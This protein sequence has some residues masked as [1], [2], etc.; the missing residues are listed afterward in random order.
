MRSLSDK[1]QGS[2]GD[3]AK[4][5]CDNGI[6]DDRIR[7]LPVNGWQGILKT[8]GDRFVDHSYF[9]T[10]GLHWANTNGGFRDDVP[11]VFAFREGLQDTASYEWSER[12]SEIVGE[13]MVYL[14]IEEPGG[15]FTVCECISSAVYLVINEAV[16]PS[17]YYITDKK[18]NWLIS[19][20]HH[21][22]VMF[23][24]ESLDV[25]KIKAVVIKKEEGKK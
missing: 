3:I 12:L 19:E 1:W 5:I 17:D 10:Y 20:N 16:Y 18:F 9:Y 13:Q 7:L 6:E 2:R 15:K 24:G 11:V 21:D 4:Y 23:L 22:V 14:L 25:E 8:V